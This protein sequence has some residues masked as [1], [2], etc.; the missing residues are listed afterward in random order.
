M[1][2]CHIRG[3]GWGPDEIFIMMTVMT[4]YLYH[5]PDWRH[6]Q[7]RQ[8]RQSNPPGRHKRETWQYTGHCRTGVHPGD[9]PARWCLGWAAPSGA[10]GKKLNN[11]ETMEKQERTW[12]LITVVNLC[13]P[14]AGLS[15]DVESEASRTPNCGKTNGSGR[16]GSIASVMMLIISLLC[17]WWPL[18]WDWCNVQN[19]ITKH[20]EMWWLIF[21]F[22]WLLE[23]SEFGPRLGGRR[24]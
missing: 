12:E 14:V 5:S 4:N 11:L 3:R 7:S 21:F 24:E 15:E 13:F 23:L 18:S 22:L 1:W 16:P 6:K 17:W 19:C 10:L 9:T 8:S 20:G 2:L